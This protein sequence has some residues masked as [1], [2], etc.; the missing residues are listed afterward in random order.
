M[1]RIIGFGLA[2]LIVFFIF[3]GVS[4]SDFEGA[5]TGKT[6]MSFKTEVPADKDK[7]SKIQPG[8]I[9]IPNAFDVVGKHINE[10]NTKANTTDRPEADNA[11]S[12]KG[13]V[14]D[15]G[16]AAINNQVT[17]QGQVTGNNSK[18]NNDP[19]SD[20]TDT[21]KSVKVRKVDPKKPMV[22][23][24]FD[25]GPHPRYTAEIL[26]ALKKNDGL[27]T[28]FILG[29]RAEKY[30]DAVKSIA[31]SG[32][33]IGN[34]TYDHKELTKL[35]KSG[36]NNEI[37][38]TAGILEN[39][40]GLSNYVIRPTYGSVNG[41]VKM[42]AG[43]PLILWSIDTLD[44]KTRDKNKIV[45]QALKRVKD[46]D[47]F[48]MHDIYKTTADAAEV[49]IRELKAKGYQLVTIDELYQARGVSLE[50]GKEY[51]SCPPAVLNK[52]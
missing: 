17:G 1:R 31:K 24:T 33:Q 49:V 21:A 18:A 34:H 48:L 52:K 22:A 45:Q 26:D 47:I 39:I 12:N 41:N 37:N 11:N 40:T 16:K 8:I 51:F 13:N 19:L 23:L 4:R 38:K 30:P 10:Q 32:N 35:N 5:K 44:W 7:K 42:Y 50:N 27:A 29:S 43:S 25:D 6:L 14:P 20:K 28:F 9:N 46:G 3:V 36:I 2:V 15:T